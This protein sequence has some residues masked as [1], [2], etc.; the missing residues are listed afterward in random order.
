[1]SVAGKG[2][3]AMKS[4]IIN[5]IHNFEMV[6]KEKP[7]ASE[8]RVILKTKYVA[9]CGSDNMLWN[10][11]Q[12]MSIG[13]EFS[14]YIEDPGDFPFKKGA[15]V[16]AA[17]FN[18]CG[19]C[20]FCKNGQEHLCRQMM[21]DNPGV[22]MDGAFSEYFSVRGDFVCELPDD[23]PLELGAIAEPVAVSLH[24]VKYCNIQPGDAVL[25]WGNG[26]I[27]IYAAACAKLLGVGKVY[28][29]GRNQGRVNFCRNYEF[30][31]DCF[32][33]KD[34]NFNE[35]L[36]A[37]TPEEGFSHVIDCLGLDDYDALVELMASGATLVLLGMHAQRTSAATMP[38]FLKEIS[39]R[40]GLYFTAA[41]Y[42]EAFELI[43]ANKELFLKTITSRIPHDAKA[44]QDMFVKLFESGSN[45]ECKV[46]IEYED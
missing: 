9:I 46:V 39:I 5:P 3:C 15:R 1:M 10:A 27:G 24:G 31:D 16:C 42:R 17:E 43:C 8:G 45:D 2:V 22:S 11:Y 21:V 33:V 37:V 20:K 35:Q 32:S 28:M 12:G 18:P 41:D 6:E 36:R 13:H 40:T 7:K 34:E 26:P 23:V 29:V 4:L 44:V 14:G 19:Q 25:I 38:M 30:V